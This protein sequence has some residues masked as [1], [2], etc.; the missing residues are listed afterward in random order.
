MSLAP[1]RGLP[2][3]TSYGG[4]YSL[5][6]SLRITKTL[7]NSVSFRGEILPSSPPFGKQPVE[8]HHGKREFCVGWGGRLGNVEWSP[9][10]NANFLVPFLSLFSG[11]N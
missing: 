3:T 8:R 9:K 6:F 11:W 2:H 10:V 1:F 7:C 5:N 4:A